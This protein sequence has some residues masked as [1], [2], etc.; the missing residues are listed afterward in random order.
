MSK[1]ETMNIQMDEDYSKSFV[2]SFVN[3][4]EDKNQE[5]QLAENKIKEKKR[6]QECC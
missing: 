2:N 1:K 4:L 5:I 6:I 3:D